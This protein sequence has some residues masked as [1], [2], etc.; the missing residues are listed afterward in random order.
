M[1]LLLD[2]NI[3]HKLCLPLR[4]HFEEVQHIRHLLS[5]EA[6]DLEI[7]EHA[8]NHNFHILTKDNDFDEWSLVKGCPPKV[9][10][11]LCG[12][13][14]TLFILNFILRNNDAIQNFLSKSDDCILKLHL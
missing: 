11:L 9:I 14:T 3:S 1:K 7:W 8:K 4:Q 6:T 10:H 5:V 2:N 12:N 13:Q